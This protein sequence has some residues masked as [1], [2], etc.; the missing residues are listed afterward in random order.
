MRQQYQR[1]LPG[2]KKARL[3]DMVLEEVKQFLESEEGRTEEVGKLLSSYVPI[4]KEKV[5]EYVEKEPDA[6]AWIDSVKD[7]HLQKGLE[8]WKSNHLE[9]MINDEI[10]K[11]FPEKSEQELEVERLKSEINKM[12]LEKEKETLTNKTMQ[13]ASERNLPI[14]LAGFF[15]GENEES[16]LENLI[17]F[18]SAFQG[19]VQ[20]ALEERLKTNGYTPPKAGGAVSQDLEKMSMNDYI[21]AR[22][23]K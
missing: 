9:T 19:S 13:I 8:T 23:Q 16:T 21:K 12:K 17:V 2:Q 18:E 20:K 1:M 4:T 15:I 22:K 7:K 3:F 10:K 11:R 14:E 6:K 5:Q